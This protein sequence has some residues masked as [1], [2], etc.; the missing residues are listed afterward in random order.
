MPQALGLN[1]TIDSQVC[2]NR[3]DEG[4]VTLCKIDTALETARNSQAFSWV[5]LHF[6]NALAFAYELLA[7]PTHLAF[8]LFF[9]RR[10]THRAERLFVPTLIPIQTLAQRV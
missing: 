2:D 10:N 1:G 5:S 6:G 9:H 3:D 4:T 7:L 8:P